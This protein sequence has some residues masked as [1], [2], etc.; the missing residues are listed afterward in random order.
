MVEQHTYSLL[1]LS[2]FS[3]DTFTQINTALSSSKRVKCWRSVKSFRKLALVYSVIFFP[4][5]VLN[6]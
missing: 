5:L 3:D 2:K 1:S 6:P 4:S